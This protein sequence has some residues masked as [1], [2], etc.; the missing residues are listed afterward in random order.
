LGQFGN[1]FECLEEQRR[2][3]KPKQIDG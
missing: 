3:I 2:D 1:R